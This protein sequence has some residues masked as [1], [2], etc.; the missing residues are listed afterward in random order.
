MGEQAYRRV[1]TGL[2]EQGRSAIVI[3]GPL[4][5]G[6]RTSGRTGM[7]WRTET[8]TAD[9]SGRD[10]VTIKT[11]TVEGL[12]DGGTR[13]F[14]QGFPP[15]HG[16]ELFW[17]ATDTIDY[18]TMLEGEVVF[19]TETG[20]VTLRR[21]DLLVDRGISHAWRND[22]DSEAIASIVIIPADPLG[23]ERT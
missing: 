13:F 7:V 8:A 4:L 19:I 2:N 3:D 23:K 15:G 20:E 22:T 6:G 14:V 16:A 12:S 17:H 9:N 1:I 18:I 21:G 5:A 11:V 10:D